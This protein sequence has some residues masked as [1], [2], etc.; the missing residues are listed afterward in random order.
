MEEHPVRLW[1]HFYVI[2]T[3]I[4][5]AP[6]ISY[7]NNWNLRRIK[8]YCDKKSWKMEKVSEDL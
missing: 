3:V 6:I 5:I 8:L 2:T 7:M 1:A 4:R